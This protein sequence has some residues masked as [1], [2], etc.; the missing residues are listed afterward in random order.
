MPNSP[1]GN[2]AV[3]L[4]QLAECSLHGDKSRVFE[5][6]VREMNCVNSHFV[7]PMHRNGE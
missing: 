3:R 7:E 1:F 4:G 5:R 6:I 2:L